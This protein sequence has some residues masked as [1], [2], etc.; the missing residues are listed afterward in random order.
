[1]DS[2]FL[3]IAV[4]LLLLINLAVAQEEDLNPMG[5]VLWYMGFG[6]GLIIFAFLSETAYK[7]FNSLYSGSADAIPTGGKIDYKEDLKKRKRI[8]N[9][10]SIAEKQRVN[11][12]DTTQRGQVAKNLFRLM[13]YRNSIKLSDASKELG[14]DIV[15][16]SRAAM[17]LKTKGLIEIGGDRTDPYLKS[18][19]A[20]L[21]KVKDMGI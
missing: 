12:W 19:K 10:L 8:M 17:D 5:E 2:K 11:A 21:E 7:V 9:Q 16:M 1:M 15:T 6:V 4:S 14:V 3:F 13:I 18:T 20:F